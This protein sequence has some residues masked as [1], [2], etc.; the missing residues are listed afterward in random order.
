MKDLSEIPL[1]ITMIGVCTLLL[2]MS[3]NW[4]KQSL[5]AEVE[6]EIRAQVLLDLLHTPAE[7]RST[8]VLDLC[9]FALAHSFLPKDYGPAYRLVRSE[10]F[11]TF[12][13]R[14]HLA[15]RFKESEAEV[16]GKIE[17]GARSF[18]A[19][20]WE[21]ERQFLEAMEKLI[22]GPTLEIE[23]SEGY[24][25]PGVHCST[26]FEKEIKNIKKWIEE[27][28]KEKVEEV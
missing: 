12:E 5:K 20:T 2:L 9:F 14:L 25:L 3:T 11:D 8:R 4:C 13:L 22:E 17:I 23:S 6:I 16:H 26:G 24:H 18:I 28:S 7:Q 10:D 19:L 1:L 27:Q 15:E 21:E